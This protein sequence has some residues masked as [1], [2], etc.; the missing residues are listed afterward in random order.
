MQVAAAVEHRL[1]LGFSSLLLRPGLDTFRQ[2][3][4]LSALR[5]MFDVVV[6][7]FPHVLSDDCHL[8][9][10]VDLLALVVPSHLS[11]L[12]RLKNVLEDRLPPGP[13]WDRIVF[14]ESHATQISWRS[15]HSS[16]V[17]VLRSVPYDPEWAAATT[18]EWRSSRPHALP[19]RYSEPTLQSALSL[20]A[21]ELGDRLAV[22]VDFSKLEDRTRRRDPF[23]FLRRSG[24]SAPAAPSS[25]EGATLDL[26]GALVLNLRWDWHG[27]EIAHCTEG[28]EAAWSTEVREVAASLVTDGG[29]L[30]LSGLVR[31]ISTAS[32]LLE[33]PAS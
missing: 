6:V 29:R 19:L 22:P 31:V 3:L 18:P 21:L 7:D 12:D 14:V 24:S 16:S 1:D 10:G 11:V 30:T 33:H 28:L 32:A 27:E 9:A 13:L 20:L 2:A 23:R 15:K 4:C 5:D 25:P 8:D 26:M 17:P